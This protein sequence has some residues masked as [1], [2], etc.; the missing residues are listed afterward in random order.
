MSRK[1]PIGAVVQDIQGREDCDAGIVCEPPPG[2]DQNDYKVWAVWRS[3]GWER[4]LWLSENETE[5]HP[6]PDPILAAYTAHILA[7]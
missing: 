6:D 4:K 3:D 5:L 2:W 7:Q 1:F